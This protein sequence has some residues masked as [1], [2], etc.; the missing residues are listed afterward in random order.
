MLMEQRSVVERE[1]VTGVLRYEPVEKSRRALDVAA[2]ER[3]LGEESAVGSALVRGDAVELG[4]HVGLERRVSGYAT[5]HDE[6]HVGHPREGGDD[7]D[8]VDRG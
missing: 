7:P 6:G 2:Q 5:A 3:P 8:N 1:R 4:E